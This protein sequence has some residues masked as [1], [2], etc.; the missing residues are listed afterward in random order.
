[1]E[2]T[3]R[4]K[5]SGPWTFEED[6]A[7]IKLVNIYGTRKWSK[8]SQFLPGRIRKQC[9]ERWFNQ[10]DPS[11]KRDKWTIEEDIKVV[12]LHLISGMKWC[13]I[14]KQLPGRTDNSIK[15]RY[16]ANL[17]KRLHEEPF[18]TI[19]RLSKPDQQVSNPCQYIQDQKSNT[20]SP[21]DKVEDISVS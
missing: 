18:L 19:S 14:A 11:I 16:N 7:L 4:G 15:N 17:C 2:L 5:S 6:R 1:M 8:V 21:K 13:Q 10:L 20:E 3:N 9:R 12:E